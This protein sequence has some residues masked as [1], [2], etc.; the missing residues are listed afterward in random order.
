MTVYFVERNFNPAPGEGKWMVGSNQ[1]IGAIST[2]RTKSKAV[3]KAKS[4]AGPG[5]EVALEGSD[6]SGTFSQIA[7]F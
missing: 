3:K 6:S 7:K 5:D 1:Q 2:H 4:Y